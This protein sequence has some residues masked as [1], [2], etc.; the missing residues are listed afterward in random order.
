MRDQASAPRAQAGEE[1]QPARA[2]SV[3]AR[4][5]TQ[6]ATGK[7]E[8]RPVRR[9]RL[10]DAGVVLALVAGWLAWL[11]PRVVRDWPITHDTFRDA[12]AVHNVLAGH[13]RADPVIN[14][15]TYWYAP[16]SPMV[17]TLV[18]R[19]SGAD[20]LV[21]YSSSI[22]WWNVWLA[23]LLYLLLRTCLDRPTALTGVL[24]VWL[25]ARWWNTH[26][27]QPQ[28]SIQGVVFVLGTLLLWS[29]G[30][31]RA[32]GWAVLTGAGLAV[33]TW[34]HL[35]CALVT[36]AAIGGHALVVLVHPRPGIDRVGMVRRVA[37]V[38][39]VCA[40]LVGPLA[41]RLLNIP[42]VNLAPIRY[43]APE[44]GNPR[45]AY[46]SQTPLVPILAILGAWLVLRCHVAKAGWLPCLAAVGLL[47]SL[48]GHFRPSPMRDRFVLLP[49]EFQWHAHL[50]L[51]A[52]AAIGVMQFARS[53]GWLARARPRLA[54]NAAWLGMM[55]VMLGPDLA[56]LPGRISIPWVLARP[57]PAAAEAAAWI[58][59]HT[60]ITD[61]FLA[62]VGHSYFL[63]G[64]RTGRKLFSPSP[65]HSHFAFDAQAAGAAL[66]TV[67]STG[68]RDELM[69]VLSRRR[70]DYA[71]LGPEQVDRADLWQ[72]W[73][74]AEPV[75]RSADGTLTIMRFTVRAEAEAAGG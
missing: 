52:L 66:E 59:K 36:T 45:Y 62:D 43:V 71:L 70:A 11:G 47:G 46:F 56:R 53:V 60:R 61:V 14:G 39:V 72:G 29:A 42:R 31:R 63:V 6:C 68:D 9:G 22:L 32:L 26:A 50:A 21:A 27:A 16:L 5:D 15:L 64:A 8:Q 19:A 23:P 38:A 3:D 74:V 73:S 1:S 69:S 34:H 10:I 35:I 2:G 4:P 28:P 57:A 49:H 41:W 58:K 48:P 12:A 44:F 51:G 7:G 40:I 25:G 54:R 65:G 18:C 17:M 13:W 67:L 55:G 33:C 24:C 75:F 30:R 37:T 20:P